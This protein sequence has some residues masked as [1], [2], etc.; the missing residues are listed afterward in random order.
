[1]I[2]TLAQINQLNDLKA[3]LRAKETSQATEKPPVTDGNLVG[4]LDDLLPEET[5]IDVLPPTSPP[6]R[7]SVA[8]AWIENASANTCRSSSPTWQTMPPSSRSTKRTRLSARPAAPSRTNA[9]P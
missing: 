5:Q 7:Y 8:D 3:E 1:M 9:Q 2:R 4:I 6:V